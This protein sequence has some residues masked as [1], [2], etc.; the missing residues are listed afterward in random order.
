MRGQCSIEDCEIK[1]YARG[2]CRNHYARW[3]SRGGDPSVNL[4][5]I[6]PE[7][8]RFW[9]KVDKTPTCWLWTAHIAPTGYGTFWVAGDGGTNVFAH[10]WAYLSAVGPI[11]EGLVIDHLCR[12]RNC[13]NP[14]HLEAVTQMENVRRW[15]RSITHCPQGHEYTAANSAVSRQGY[16]T[17]RACARERARARRA[18]LR[19]AA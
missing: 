11:P 2:W 14:S 5:A 13:V 4:S 9:S 18:R 12:V 17:C 10:R 8:D 15:S 3:Q 19:S 7:A 6:V 1:V 16:R